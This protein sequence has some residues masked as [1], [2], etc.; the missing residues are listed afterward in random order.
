MSAYPPAY[1]AQYRDAI[2]THWWFRGR[3]R[4][5]VELTRDLV[6]ISPRDIVLDIGSGPGGPARAL[7]PRAHIIGLDIDHGV[8]DAYDT[9]NAHLVADGMQLPCRRGSLSAVCAFDILEHLDDD[10]GALTEWRQAT[11]PDGWLILT[12]PALAMLWGTH[13]E[14]NH[15]RRRYDA[16]RLRQLCDAA[17]YAVERLTYFNSVLLPGIALVRWTQRLLNMIAARPAA[18][19]TE[20]MLDC[21]YKLP[22]WMER[23]CEWILYAEARWLR[24]RTLPL[25]VSL[26]VVARVRSSGVS[27][28]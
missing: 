20:K 5:V 24:Q 4:I 3:E 28:R 22:R 13:D 19:S 2:R 21:Q 18:S 23:S 27:G 11:A 6:E 15:H 10:L 14:A 1:Y 12:V 17:G 26:G 25:G 16:Q 8:L 7:F 9:A